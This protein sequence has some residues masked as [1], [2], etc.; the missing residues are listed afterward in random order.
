MSYQA[1][2][3]AWR[4]E[5]F[6]EICG[7]EAITRTLKRQVMTGRI[8]HA[9]LFCGTRGT[10]KT[11]A[12]K[13]LSRAINCLNPRDGDPC[14]EC[15]ICLA[16]KQESSMDVLEI[17][18][19]SNN[20]VDEIRDLREKI[21]YPPAMTRYKVYII[22]EVHMLS[23]GAFNALL[24]TLEEPP[25]HAVFILA[26]TEPQKLP[27]T[28]LSR[29][30]RFSF[31]RLMPEDIA[32]RINEC[33]WREGI[34][35]DQ[36]AIALLSRLADGAMRDGMSLLDQCASATQGPVTVES[37]YRCL[38]LAGSQS[39]VQMLS[40][41]ADK[42]TAEL[43]GLFSELYAAGKDL[44][45]MVD[46]LTALC[47]DLLIL[48]TA[49]RSGMSLIS[50]VCSTEE[51]NTLLPKFTADALL[52]MTELL[53]QT[54]SGFNRTANRRIDVELCLIRLCDDTLSPDPQSIASRL[55]RLEAQAASGMLAAPAAPAAPAPKE[56]IPP[57]RQ[58][59]P[60]A[61]APVPAPAEPDHFWEKLCACVQPLLGRDAAW[62]FRPESGNAVQGRLQND[63]FRVFARD[64]F[65]LGLVKKYELPLSQCAAQLLGKPVRLVAAVQ[66]EGEQDSSDSFDQL[67]Q[68]AQQHSDI[69]HIQNNT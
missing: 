30:Q 32:G 55:S 12:A 20:G 47:R 53:Q 54:A 6:S 15:E 62:L 63:I 5:T 39:T 8:A 2:Y 36:P 45:A 46:E 18:A 22:D 38:G 61:A 52:R 66:S 67:L 28:I 64:T 68:F 26:T 1:L 7:Q 42:A 13:V 44:G 57:P 60:K 17:D 43:L 48:K 69:V 35:I 51:L 3:R 10:G 4:P 23:T 41:A 34:E 50:G 56:Q 19:A 9:Y 11:T 27:A 25:G 31:R 33:A 29:C 65:T 16:L 58:E 49:P 21:K 37:I 40:Y 14:G 24:K 59:A